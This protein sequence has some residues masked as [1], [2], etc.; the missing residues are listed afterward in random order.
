MSTFTGL[1]NEILT[2]IIEAIEPDDIESFSICCKLMYSLARQRI[3]EH[4]EKKSLF[5]KLIVA[6][7]SLS[8][9]GQYL[10]KKHGETEFYW[11]E[12]FADERNR[13]YPNAMD[14]DLFDLSDHETKEYEGSHTPRSP[15]DD[16]LDDASHQLKRTMAEICSKIGLEC[17]GNEAV[18][19]VKQVQ[20]GYPMATFL[21]LLALLPNLKK[22]TISCVSHWSQSLSEGYIWI[23][24]HMTETILGQEVDGLAFG[25]SLSK[26]T[27]DGGYTEGIG[28][29]LLPFF[30]MLPRMQKIRGYALLIE[31][32]SWPYTEA[33]A[34]VVDLDLEG[35]IDSLSIGN[36]VSGIKELK[37]FRFRHIHYNCIVW[38]PYWI[39][40]ALKQFALSSLVS[41]DLTNDKGPETS[42]LHTLPGIGSLRSFDV[43]EKIRLQHI[44]LFEDVRT[45][46]G[47]KENYSWE[48]LQDLIDES[49]VIGQKLIDFLPS[50]ARAFRLEDL[51]M[52]SHVLDIFKGFSE[53]RMERL[54]KLE[55]VSL[56]AGRKTNSQIE[57]I[58]KKSGVQ[59]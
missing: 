26:C 7:H 32:S 46:D 22:F 44:L 48:T 49:F 30:M 52:R 13:F 33:V 35:G 45:S 53:H 11:K 16:G 31:D 4:K 8:F 57:K 24:A 42:L 56:D 14:V 2:A 3:E 19:W 55:L 25:G 47:A 5:S 37:R 20:A 12:F 41:L 40:A 29:S 23:M 15:G 39:V 34:P 54:P 50:S 51:L 18:E 17:E 59:M 1:P 58:C 36:Y 6:N 10:D 9:P 21:L 28:E 27:I 38:E 43:L